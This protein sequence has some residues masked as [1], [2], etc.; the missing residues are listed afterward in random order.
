MLRSATKSRVFESMTY[1]LLLELSPPFFPHS[2]HS[3]CAVPGTEYKLSKCLLNSAFEPNFLTH[4]QETL[5]LLKKI[6]IIG[7]SPTETPDKEKG[8]WKHFRLPEGSLGKRRGLERA[9]TPRS[10][11]AWWAWLEEAVSHS[12]KDLNGLVHGIK[13]RQA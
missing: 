3:H 6:R 1:C 13:E 11:E 4:S 7:A 9:K 5:F 12:C 8:C 2:Q 10:G